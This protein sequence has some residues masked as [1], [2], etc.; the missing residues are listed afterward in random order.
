MESNRVDCDQAFVL[1]KGRDDKKEAA[2]A[3][4]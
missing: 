3:L 2:L 1:L 4:G